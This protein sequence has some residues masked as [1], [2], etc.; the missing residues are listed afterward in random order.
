MKKE[1]DNQLND[2]INESPRPGL[3]DDRKHIE[4][5]ARPPK[6]SPVVPEQL[7]LDSKLKF[8]CY[9]GISCFTA[10]C[11][12]IDIMLTPYDVL[13]M[14]NRL[15]IS[16]D[17]FLEKYTRSRI[18]EKTGWPQLLLLMGEGEE[19][20]CPFV[21]E[22]GCTIYSDR[23]AM[24]RYYPVGQGIHRREI[25]GEV[26]NREFYM[27]IREDH[28]RGFEEDKRWTIAEWRENQEASHYDEMNR[29]WKDIFIRRVT[30]EEDEDGR[31]QQIFFIASYNIDQF[32][33]FVFES[34]LLD[35]FVLDDEYVDRIREDE[36]ELMRFAFRYL[37]F[38]FGVEKDLELR[39][40]A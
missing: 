30:R 14:K 21:T 10:C 8:A 17:E 9:P 6:Q 31:R 4:E 32:R 35:V 12:N 34:R 40:G 13:R 28:C 20:P 25:E 18:D 15:G 22:E 38:L 11:G 1:D 26:E 24:C 33:K 37:R 23:P 2:S 5:Q 29:D 7:S 39:E 16:S 36:L 19:R 27:L 3:E